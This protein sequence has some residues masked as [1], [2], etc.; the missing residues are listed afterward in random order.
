MKHNPDP[1]NNEFADSV[2]PLTLAHCSKAMAKAVEALLLRSM[3]SLYSLAALR[4]SWYAATD[5]RN[6]AT[7]ISGIDQNSLKFR[8]HISSARRM[9]QPSARGGRESTDRVI[10][11]RTSESPKS[12]WEAWVAWVVALSAGEDGAAVAE[13][14]EGGGRKKGRNPRRNELPPI[15]T[16]NTLPS[17]GATEKVV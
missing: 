5:A 4:S 14:A 10:I 16:A 12:S 2:A 8:T 3:D 9:G 15:S 1:S 13:G 17:A 11:N 7:R 6:F